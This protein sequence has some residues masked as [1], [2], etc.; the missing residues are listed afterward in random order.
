[1]KQ[2]QLIGSYGRNAADFEATLEWAAQGKLKPVID[3]IVP[4]ADAP[5]AYA[6]LRA[7]GV[8]GKIVVRP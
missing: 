1:V 2:Q 4:L 7:R 6:Q 5:R 8:L 3:S